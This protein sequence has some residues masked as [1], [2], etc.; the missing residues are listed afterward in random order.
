[1]ADRA[2]TPLQAAAVEDIKRMRQQGI[3]VREIARRTGLSKTFVHNVA[4]GKSGISAGRAQTTLSLADDD[5]WKGSVVTGAD[6]RLVNPLTKRDR[7][8]IGRYWSKMRQARRT[9][10]FGLIKRELSNAGLRIN[11][12]EGKITLQSDPEIL[13][14][15][16]ELGELNPAEI[17]I[18]E[19]A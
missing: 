16:D 7:S 8:K 6:V 2:I 13:R 1:M 9:G 17:W 4:R 3:S 18:G 14:E 15:L 12:T 11:T 5:A 19:S 10:D